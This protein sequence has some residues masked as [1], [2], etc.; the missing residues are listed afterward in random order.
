[1]KYIFTKKRRLEDFE[2]IAIA[3]ECSAIFQKKL[4]QKLKEPTSFNCACTIGNQV[5]AQGLCDLGTNINW[6]SLPIYWKLGLRESKLSTI[7]L[8]LADRTLMYL[9]VVDKGML[10]KIDI[11]VFLANFIVPDIEDNKNSII[12]R[13]PFLETR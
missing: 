2:M 3:E 4:P 9:R 6:M 11:F 12:L 5:S 13:R 10:V 7:I 1:M 8:Q